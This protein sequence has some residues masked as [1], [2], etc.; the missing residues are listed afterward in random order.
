[1]KKRKLNQVK[2]T[3]SEMFE[4]P[5]EITLNLPKISMIGISR[6]WL[7][8]TKELSNTPQRIRLNST[9][10]VLRVRA[11]MNLRISL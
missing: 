7:K 8:I 4:L 6:C 11:N 5:K 2:S 9:I 3:V 1:M 10:G